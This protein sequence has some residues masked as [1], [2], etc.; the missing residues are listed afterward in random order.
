[1]RFAI[2]REISPAIERCALTH[3]A[4]QSIDLDRAR[5][6]HE[7]YEGRLRELGCAVVRLAADEAMP[8]SVFVEDVAVVFDEV[9]VITRPGA[10]SRH[11]EIPAI[12]EALAPYRLLQSIQPPGRLDGGDVLTV[13]R[14]VFI[15]QTRRTNL[16]ALR[17]MKDILNPYGYLV[18]GVA[19]DRCLHL[20]SAVSLVADGCLL[21]NPAWA[22]T[23]NF[24]AFRLI[25]TDPTEP[26]AANALR[27]WN[28]V[29]YP[30]MFP[31][32]VRRLEDEGIQIVAVD[33]SE[34]AKAEGGVTCC[35][36][37]FEVPLS[38]A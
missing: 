11:I 7:A 35:S 10:E 32:T 21:I 17:Q 25:T 14:Q 24:H 31:K 23:D 12:A 36:L 34:L 5:R 15:G 26:F 18:E 29:I 33:S 38:K 3:L 4:R 20:K 13:G 6:Q 1:M 37:I 27:I 30:S 2:T 16:A 19:V 8:D 28:S 9:G 22:P